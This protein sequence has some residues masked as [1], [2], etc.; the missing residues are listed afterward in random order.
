M[1]PMDTNLFA[2]YKAAIKNAVAYTSKLTDEAWAADEKY[3]LRTAGHVRA[4]ML[5]V[6]EWALT[7]ARIV[8]DIKR[9]PQHL[10][11]VADAKGAKVPPKKRMLPRPKTRAFPPPPDCPKTTAALH[12]LFAKLDASQQELPPKKRAHVE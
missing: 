10:K 8:Q 5:R 6:W 3:K 2:D 11:D 1:D 9:W 12:V 7:S 4:T